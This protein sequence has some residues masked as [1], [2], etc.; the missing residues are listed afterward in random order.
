MKKHI[1]NVIL[2]LSGGIGARFGADCP[3]QY[4]IMS[5]RPVIDYVI[6]ACRRSVY[7][8]EIVVVSSRMYYEYVY[9][10]FNVT[11]VVGGETRAES[12]ACGIQYIQENYDCEKVVI[13]NA[14][15]PLATTEQYDR[16]FEYLDEYDFVLT[17]WKLTGALHR[18]D[19]KRVDRDEYFNI[20]AP[21][22]YRFKKLYKSFNFENPEKCLFHNM[23]ED[24]KPYFCFDYPY[25]TKVTY[26]FDIPILETLYAELVEKPKKDNTLQLVNKYLS[27]DGTMGIE[28][29][30][31]DVQKNVRDITQKYGITHYTINPL[32]QA[33]IL[34]EG[35]SPTEG[36][37]TIKF[38]PSEYDYYRELTYYKLNSSGVMVRL[39]GYDDD[40]H[41]I[42][43]EKVKPGLQVKFHSEN[44][45]LKVI[46]DKISENLISVS[47]LKGNSF[48]PQF[49]EEFRQFSSIAD[50]HTF[51]YDYR[52]T[53]KK[54]A[55]R[56]WD[57]YF[58]NAPMYF[59]HGDIQRQ[60]II[61]SKDKVYIINPK[62][63]I[64]PFEFEYVIQF[65]TELPEDT[66]NSKFIES[67]HSIMKY[68]TR[69]ADKERLMAALYIFWV[70]KMNDYV[71]HKSD[72]Y[73]LAAWCKNCILK[74]FFD[75]SIENAMDDDF[76]P[77]GISMK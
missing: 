45:K 8:D 66:E 59:I 53:I 35:Y 69:Y 41:V 54:K 1:K 43:L 77:N 9:D 20:M 32:V 57:F 68:F 38:S 23:P 65:V 46:Y 76:P 71:F 25:T 61:S 62:G 55:S 28:G 40:L 15:C 4:N 47:L 14:V 58:E 73:K 56:V 27:A 30:V 72:N 26:S 29:W 7:A 67:F 48:V 5:G 17:A 18:F 74:L 11:T 49:K 31:Q 60:N 70:H 33:S 64:A 3:K 10:R 21:D 52:K 34:Y 51:E 22:A 2:V 42:V 63:I 12:V 6:D 13:T 36:D 37:L 39:V 16:Y 19:G 24:S 75:S 44:D 50:K